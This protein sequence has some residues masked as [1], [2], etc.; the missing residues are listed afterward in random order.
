MPLS[1][2]IAACE[3]KLEGFAES[4]LTVL[5]MQM[6]AVKWVFHC[7]Q[8]RRR[9]EAARDINGIQ[10]VAPLIDTAMH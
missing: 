2:A 9:S 3:C 5:A 4:K 6:V 8:S 10:V 7:L 1:F